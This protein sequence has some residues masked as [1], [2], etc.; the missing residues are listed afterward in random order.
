VISASIA[1]FYRRRAC[2]MRS[3]PCLAALDRERATRSRCRA[4]FDSQ[5]LTRSAMSKILAKRTFQCEAG[6]FGRTN[7]TAFQCEAGRFGQTNPISFQ[8]V[9][10]HFG[11]TNPTGE[12][13]TNNNNIFRLDQLPSQRCATKPRG[14]L[15]WRVVGARHASPLQRRARARRRSFWQNEPKDSNKYNGL[16]H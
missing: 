1:R 13:G 5:R 7:P 16:N 6:H 12:S 11:Q 8:C 9:A 4:I 10:D 15:D 2:G 14:I 3:G